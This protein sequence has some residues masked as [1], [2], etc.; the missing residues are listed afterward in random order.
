MDERGPC[1]PLHVSERTP[2][3]CCCHIRHVVG[4]RDGVEVN[5]SASCRGSIETPSILFDS[6]KCS[7]MYRLDVLHGNMFVFQQPA[8]EPLKPGML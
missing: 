6:G 8:Q 5:D 3:R 4:S 1:S 2:F 7:N